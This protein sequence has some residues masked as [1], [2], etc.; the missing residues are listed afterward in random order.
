MNMKSKKQNDMK[1]KIIEPAGKIIETLEKRGFDA[2]L[3]GGCVRDGLL[4]ISPTDYD[5]ATNALPSQVIEVFG[6]S[7]KDN[8]DNTLE[9]YNETL[10]QKAYVVETGIA[11]GTVTVVIESFPVEVTT[12]RIDG[13]YTD[14][15]RPDSVSF[16]SSINDDLSRRDF[17]I[18]AMAYSDKTGIID[19]FNGRQDLHDRIIKCVGDP[20][21]RFSEDSL[22]ILRAVRFASVLG[23]YI[24]PGTKSA[25]DMLRN[26]IGTVATERI[27][28]EFTKLLCGLYVENILFEFRDMIAV[29]IPE[30]SPCFDFLQ[31]NPHHSFDVYTHLVK[32]VTYVP[33]RLPLRLTA[34]FHDIGKPS[35]FFKDADGI[36]HFYGHQKVGSEMVRVILDRLR[37]DNFTKK[38]TYELVLHHDIHI[39]ADKKSI[40]HILNRFSED[41]FLDLLAL[42]KADV[43]AQQTSEMTGRIAFLDELI[44]I[45]EE[46]IEENACFSLKD[47]AITGEDILKL[48]FMPGRQIGDILEDC[49][50]QVIGEHLRNDKKELLDYIIKMKDKKK[51]L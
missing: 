47:L 3:V 32:A 4:G 15:R 36:G 33:A 13:Q 43:S 12:F 17:T 26:T 21:S 46:I 9:D 30:I 16:S 48:G 1:I 37:F 44:R 19:P 42:K 28:A 22:R 6:D 25:I 50:H 14:N 5:I 40:K 31:H 51:G 34:L 45:Y 29:I 18:N 11:H 24:E 20:E 39:E 38:R 2:F 10:E 27:T 49:L 8:V 35:T 41:F 23:F 7:F